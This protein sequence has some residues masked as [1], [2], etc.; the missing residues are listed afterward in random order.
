MRPPTKIRSSAKYTLAML[1][2]SRNERIQTHLVDHLLRLG[3][4]MVG[5]PKEN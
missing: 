2:E 5:N 4:S 1:I 3:I